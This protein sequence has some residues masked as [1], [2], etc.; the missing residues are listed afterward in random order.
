MTRFDIACIQEAKAHNLEC[1]RHAL[2]GCKMW[3]S[4]TGA[5]KTAEAGVIIIVRQSVLH[6][7]DINEADT[8]SSSTTKGRGRIVSIKL[9]PKAKST[10]VFSSCRV[11]NL[12]LQAGDTAQNMQDKIEQLN[13][14][15]DCVPKDSDFEFMGGDLNIKTTK[16]SK[17]T[18]RLD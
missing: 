6:L 9:T 18:T 15:S 7:Y 17:A 16:S 1:L 8:Y 14:V 4:L 3:S 10:E 11:T 5:D 12:Y 2:T 13:E